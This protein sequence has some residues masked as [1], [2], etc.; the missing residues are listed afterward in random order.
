MTFLHNYHHG[1]SRHS[2]LHQ[3][4][5]LAPGK[6]QIQMAIKTNAS[7]NYLNKTKLQNILN[8]IIQ[9]PNLS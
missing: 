4:L 1:T 8:K 5:P 2:L 7:I 3:L 6:P 9:V